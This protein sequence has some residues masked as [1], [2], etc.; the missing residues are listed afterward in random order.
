MHQWAPIETTDALQLL[1]PSFQNQQVRAHA[2]AVLGATSDAEL[3]GYLLQLVQALRHEATDDSSLLRFLVARAARNPQVS[4][5]SFTQLR[6]KWE[7]GQHCTALPHC[8]RASHQTVVELGPTR[9]RLAPERGAGQQLAEG[10]ADVKEAR[11]R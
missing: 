3:L 4:D 6:A 9:T 5:V 11:A 1:S 8:T 2:V 7:G 10:R